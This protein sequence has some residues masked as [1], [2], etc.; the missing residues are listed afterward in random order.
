MNM[1]LVDSFHPEDGGGM[2]S[3]TSVLTRQFLLQLLVTANVPRS[4]ILSTLKIEAIRSSERSI[5]TTPTWCHAPGDSILLYRML[6][7]AQDYSLCLTQSLMAMCFRQIVRQYSAPEGWVG[8][9]P[10]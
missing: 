4:L 9:P 5:L 7:L 6:P 2:F 8:H 10:R 3:E 1:K